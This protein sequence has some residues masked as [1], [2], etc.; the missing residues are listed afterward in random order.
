[1]A[2]LQEIRCSNNTADI[3]KYTRSGELSGAP[4]VAKAPAE[5]LLT[6]SNVWGLAY[7]G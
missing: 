5:T 7:S 2:S 6:L 1:M 3:A 4:N